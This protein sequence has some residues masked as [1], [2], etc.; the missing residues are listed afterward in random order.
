MTAQRARART[1]CTMLLDVVVRPYDGAFLVIMRMCNLVRSRAS[2]PAIHLI[3]DV[4]KLVRFVG[5]LTTPRLQPTQGGGADLRTVHACH[6]R[7]SGRRAKPLSTTR[8]ASHGQKRHQ[9][10][11]LAQEA[12]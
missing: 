1:A 7:R 8:L 10:A 12:T 6:K 5:A 9:A 4:T 11:S 3:V 2:H